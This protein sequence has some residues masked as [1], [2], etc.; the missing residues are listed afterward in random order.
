MCS[1]PTLPDEK[2][3]SNI[4]NQ[5]R[6]FLADTAHAKAVTLVRV[7]HV[8]IAAIEVHTVRVVSIVLRGRPIVS[9]RTGIVQ[10]TGRVG[11]TV[12]DSGKLQMSKLK[13]ADVYKRQCKTPTRMSV[14]NPNRIAILSTK[15]AYCSPSSLLNLRG[16]LGQLSL[17]ACRPTLAATL[18]V[19]YGS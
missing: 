15:S 8:H 12:A 14:C 3:T 17:K 13:R 4:K 10:R 2:L 16:T 9:V 7:V 19:S 11:V 6:K 5:G 1:Y 18:I